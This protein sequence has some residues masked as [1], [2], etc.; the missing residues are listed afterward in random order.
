MS[1]IN[2]YELLGLDCKSK[3]EEVRHKFKSLAL[4]CHPDKG[5]DQK[6]MR[7]LQMAYNYVL[8]Q[9]EYGEHGRTMEEEEEKFKKFMESQV[10]EKI[11][12]IFEIMTDEANKKFNEAWDESKTEKFSMCYESHYDEKIK[13]EPDVFSTQII[14]YKEPKTIGEISFSSTYDFTVHPVKDFSDYSGSGGFD[15]VLAHSNRVFDEKIDEK[16]VMKE[17]E[18]LKLRREEEMS[19][20]Q[21]NNGIKIKLGL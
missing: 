9:I 1:L 13:D 11:P 12:S 3:R 18:E 4:I 8:E 20:S 17:F 14:E 21:G 7:I 15:Y 10:E 19:R 5:G 16:D 2:P 6:Q